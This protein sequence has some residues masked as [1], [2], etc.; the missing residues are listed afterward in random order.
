MKLTV[1]FRNFARPP[2]NVRSK[3]VSPCGGG[4]N[5][6]GKWKDGQRC[7]LRNRAVEAQFAQFLVLSLLNTIATAQSLWQHNKSR[8]PSQILTLLITLEINRQLCI[9]VLS[10]HSLWVTTSM[11]KFSLQNQQYWHACSVLPSFSKQ[12]RYTHLSRYICRCFPRF[13]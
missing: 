8:D 10:K 2:K 13:L 4:R 7:T 1:A 3:L 12:T 6:E 9:H 11:L 5:E